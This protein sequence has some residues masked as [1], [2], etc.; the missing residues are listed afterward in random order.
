MTSPDDANIFL[1]MLRV[2]TPFLIIA[3][4]FATAGDVSFNRDVRP[5]LSN[6]CY[7]CHGTDPNHRKGD[8]RL[9]T[10]EGALADIKGVKAIVPGKPNDSELIARILSDDPDTVMPPPKSNKSITSAEKEILRRWIAEGAKYEP[11]WAFVA[12]VRP[13]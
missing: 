7:Y 6:N 9:D 1:K 5:I 2:A 8:R 12:P 10:P 11:H 3:A 13:P 4:G